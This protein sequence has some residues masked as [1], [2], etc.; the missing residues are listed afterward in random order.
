MIKICIHARFTFELI[1]FGLILVRI[2][3]VEIK[4]HVPSIRTKIRH[5]PNSNHDETEFYNID[6]LILIF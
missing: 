3:L 4:T 1:K 6:N 2:L 5:N